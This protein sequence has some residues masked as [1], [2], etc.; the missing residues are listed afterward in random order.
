MTNLVV[1]LSSLCCQRGNTS[2]TNIAPLTTFYAHILKN[3]QTRERGVPD[4]VDSTIFARILFSRIALK[5]F[6]DVKNSRLRQDL[7]I[8]IN[9]R[10]ILPFREGFIFMKLRIFR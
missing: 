4:T 6:S 1:L 3:Y 9:D 10:V 7:A 2:T 8:S 5:H